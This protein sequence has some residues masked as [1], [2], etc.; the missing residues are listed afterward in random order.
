MTAQRADHGRAD[1]D[2][3]GKM[4]IHDIEVNPIGS[5]LDNGADFLSKPAEIA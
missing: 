4:A 3:R 1:G 2:V 5:G